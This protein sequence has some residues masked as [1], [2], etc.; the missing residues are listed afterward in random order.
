MSG[1]KLCIKNGKLISRDKIETGKSLFIEDGRITEIVN[2][3]KR[4][5]QGF[6]VI[7]AKGLYVSPGFIDIHVHSLFASRAANISEDDLK[8]MRDRMARSGV[9]AFLATTVALPTETLLSATN[10]VKHFIAN[11][12]GTGLLGLH[13]E[14]PYLNPSSC[15]AHNRKNIRMLKPDELKKVFSNAGGLIKMMTFAPERENGM[16]LLGFLVGHGVIPSIGHS[17]ASYK[18]TALAV[19]KGLR[20]VTHLFNAMPAFHHRDPGLIG[21]ALALDKLS[22]DIIAD[23]VH[24]H[25]ATVKFTIKAKGIDRVILISDRIEG[26]MRLKDGRLAGSVL[27][28]NQA[29]KNVME[30]ADVSLQ[31]AVR[32]AT[33]NP[34][35]LLGISGKKGSL[36]AGKDADIIIFD[37]ALVIKS[38]IVKGDMVYGHMWYN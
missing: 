7:D 19:K 16:K 32:M 20:H 10:A 17:R 37:E 11:N 26:P 1:N 30:F 4:P 24:L 9:T 6:D 36:E 12:P 14:G 33:M 35:R 15:G 23:G 29:V 22:V 27:G 25:P 8:Q 5:P 18:E 3:G 34:A 38:A 31:D 21:A 13:L 2:G 28:L